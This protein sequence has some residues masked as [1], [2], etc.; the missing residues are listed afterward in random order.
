MNLFVTKVA[1]CRFYFQV[2]QIMTWRRGME[3]VE[4]ENSADKVLEAFEAFLSDITLILAEA[5]AN[6]TRLELEDPET[7]A[8]DL[9][10]DSA[11]GVSLEPVAAD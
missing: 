1:T 10:N 8:V 3:G 11:S 7:S 6:D 4:W 2:R 5:S 9:P